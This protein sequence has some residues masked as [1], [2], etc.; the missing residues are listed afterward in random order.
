MMSLI[1]NLA[2]RFIVGDPK[3]DPEA[4]RTREESVRQLQEERGEFRQSLQRLASQH[5]VM[6]RTGLILSWEGASRMLEDKG[7]D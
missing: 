5:D 6:M 2:R 4:V 7:N 3:E 1:R